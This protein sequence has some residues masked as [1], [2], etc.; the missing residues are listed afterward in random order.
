MI[1]RRWLRVLAPW[2]PIEAVRWIGV[3]AVGCLLTV[4]GWIWTAHT[5]AMN[6][7]VTPMN[8]CIAGFIVCAYANLSFVVRARRTNTARRIDLLRLPTPHAERGAAT[9]ASWVVAAGSPPYHAAD[10]RIVVDREREAYD[11]TAGARAAC[12]LCVR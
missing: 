8:V 2:D 3:G 12:R 4:A 11:P 5:V 10:C 9:S 7:A 6:D 1:V